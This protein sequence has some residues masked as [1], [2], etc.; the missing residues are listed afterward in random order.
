MMLLDGGGMFVNRFKLIELVRL[1]EA[2]PFETTASE[3]MLPKT[4]MA[5]ATATKATPSEAMISKA[6]ASE[7][8]FSKF[9]LI[10]LGNGGGLGR[11]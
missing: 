9:K 3:A 10:C 7:A 2:A 5:K 11:W 6:A 8:N 1:I 4:M